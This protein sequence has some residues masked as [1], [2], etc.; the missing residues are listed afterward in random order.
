MRENGYSDGRNLFRMGIWIRALR[1]L[2]LILALG[3]PGAVRADLAGVEAPDFVLKSTA[4]ANLRLSEYRGR[5]VLL[6]F[7]A[8]WCGDCR[9]QMRGLTEIASRYRGADFEVL[10]VSVDTER[11]AADK[12]A[13][14][15]KLEIPVLHDAGGVVSESYQVDKM[16][17]L[18]VID[19]NG[20]V[21]AEFDGY[22]RGQEDRYVD[23][24]RA[25]LAE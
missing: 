1:L 15:L 9:A 5:V 4:G 13:D 19:R 8:S 12:A 7:W 16:P 23:E 22:E 2:L 6:G 20:I 17:Y 11:R 24:V 14:S 3:G 18:A 10:T 21:R 25:L